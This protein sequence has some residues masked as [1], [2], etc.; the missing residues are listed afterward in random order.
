MKTRHTITQTITRYKP[1][2]EG[3]RSLKVL[4][5]GKVEITFDLEPILR[6][7]AGNALSNASG[8]SSICGGNI[9][10][11]V[12]TRTQTVIPETESV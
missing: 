2:P 5:S 9:K 1:R 4:I 3:G 7:A 11:R 6:E 12:V 10:A 8:K